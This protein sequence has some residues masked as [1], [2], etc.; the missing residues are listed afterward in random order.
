MSNHR[1]LQ[2]R[3]VHLSDLH[4]GA[5]HRFTP[6]PTPAG[7]PGSARGFPSLASSVAKD[8]ASPDFDGTLW[9]ADGRHQN[10][11]LIA[12]TG[13]IS[14]TGQN[15]ELRQA[16]QCIRDLCASRPLSTDVSLKDVALIPGN[17]DLIYDKAD[18]VERWSVYCS[19][20]SALRGTSAIPPERAYD[21]SRIVDRSDEGLIV[22][23]LN[24]AFDVVKNTIETHRG[25][26]DEG[27]LDRLAGEL[28]A[29]PSEKRAR[30]L[31]IALIHHHPIVLPFF[32]EPGRGYD[33]VV[34]ATKL[35]Q[36]L[37]QHEF[38]LV[39]H[40]HKHF[41]H[42][43]SY[44]PQCAWTGD[45]PHG[46]FIVAGGSAGTID[47]NLPAKEPRA[48]NTYNV[49]ALKWNPDARHGRIR[50]VTRG[51]VTTDSDGLSLRAPQWH[52]T[53]LKS[54]DRLLGQPMRLI[55][56][57]VEVRPFDDRGD[58]PYDLERRSH[59][60]RLRGNM[61]IV[62]VIPSLDPGQAYDATVCLMPHPSEKQLEMPTRVEWCAGPMFE[63]VQASIVPPFAARFSYW[64]PANIQVRLHFKDA[65]ETH[66]VYAHAFQPWTYHN[67]IV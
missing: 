32:A 31:K 53:T 51:L 19:F 58:G 25:Q 34:G 3:I 8:L 26:I 44:D 27:V 45:L 59:Y 37:R 13:D 49:I 4:F 39:L 15:A 24:S 6:P 18:P 9:H 28:N 17:H 33:A 22:A 36:L 48:T 14:E 55:D 52:W 65:I 66:V 46:L 21:L 50:V 38:H 54:V 47:E 40:G 1:L 11:L 10:P 23:E 35:L 62:D 57:K 20:E 63:Q 16:G 5:T 42:V 29:I 30:A 64:G 56:P 12:V 60:P 2:A 7:P 67:T 43:F 61:P 41:P